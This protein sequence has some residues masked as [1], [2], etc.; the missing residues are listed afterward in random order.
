VIQFRRLVAVD[1]LPNDAVGEPIDAAQPAYEI[2]LSIVAAELFACVLGIP[3]SPS[4]CASEMSRW[5]LTPPQN[6][7]RRVVF[8]ALA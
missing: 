6:T 4:L 3:T 8:K 7:G 1:Q 5:A 2:S